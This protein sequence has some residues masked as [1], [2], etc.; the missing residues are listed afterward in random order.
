MSQELESVKRE[1]E[2]CR[3]DEIVKEAALIE[4]RRQWADLVKCRSIEVNVLL[5]KPTKDETDPKQ[6]SSAETKKNGKVTKAQKNLQKAKELNDEME[7]MFKD[8]DFKIK[9]RRRDNSKINKQ[10]LSRQV[11]FAD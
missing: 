8:E 11:Q 2:L 10:Q 9:R 1:L 3:S 6:P 7:L 5:N 4:L